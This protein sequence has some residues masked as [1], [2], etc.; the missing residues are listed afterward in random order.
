M[1]GVQRVPVRV[2]CKIMRP[3]N[4]SFAVLAAAAIVVLAFAIIFTCSVLPFA[5]L[6]PRPAVLYGH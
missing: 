5:S 3:L 4:L 6:A 1:A 2:R